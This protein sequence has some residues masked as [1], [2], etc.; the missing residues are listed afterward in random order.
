MKK[1]K[2]KV[3]GYVHSGETPPEKCPVCGASAKEFIEIQDT[4]DIEWQCSVCKY[5]HKGPEPPD[6]CPV[7]GA[8]KSK[9][10]RLVAENTATSDPKPS[11]NTHI[12][13]AEQTPLS[14]IYNFISDNIIA[15]HLHPISVHI[16]NGVIPV[17]VAFV[18]LSAFL[19]SGSVGLAAFYNTVFITLSMPIVLFTGYVEWKKRYGG[20]YTNF[21]ITKMICGGLVFAVSF[22]LTL[23]GIFDQGI[24]QNNGEI[25]W[26]YIL[27]YIIMLGAAGGAGHLGGKLVF[28]E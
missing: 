11:S 28:K 20:T 25:S 18:L 24:S 13:D 4:P 2:C 15:H 19:G 6:T 10:V 12:S 23:W 7:C 14:L 9:F 8:D 3:C 26:L 1:W 21:F 27:L 22:I 17:A 16:P 5:V